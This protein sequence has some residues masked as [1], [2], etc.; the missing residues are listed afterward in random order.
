MRIKG[1]ISF[2]GLM[3]S[4]IN[5]QIGIGQEKS[6]RRFGDVVDFVCEGD[7]IKSIFPILTEGQSQ[8]SKMTLAVVCLFLGGLGIHRFMVG[9]TGTGVV[10]FL[11]TITL[12]GAL[13]FGRLL[14]L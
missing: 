7:I 11:L 1:I 13:G 8:Q 10:M 12:V 3:V 6:R 2:Q 9:K 5:L 4:A 14:I